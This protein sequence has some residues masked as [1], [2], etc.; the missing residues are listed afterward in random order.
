MHEDWK[1]T[2]HFWLE[3]SMIII[4]YMYYHSWLD[5][6]LNF[7]YMYQIYKCILLIDVL[8]QYYKIWNLR[9]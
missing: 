4:H 1:S 5:L 2:D 8:G 9:G 7:E 3:I 6:Y